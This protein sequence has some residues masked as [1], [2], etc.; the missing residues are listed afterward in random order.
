MIVPF[1][2]RNLWHAH[3]YMALTFR[4]EDCDITLDIDAQ[5]PE[6]SDAWCVQLARS[7]FDHGW[8]IPPPDAHGLLDTMTSWCP[9]C[10]LKR[11][12]TQVHYEA[13]AAPLI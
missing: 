9:Q 1:D 5:H 4:C 12:L 8:F 3:A 7:G 10:G 11:E 13:A 6:C 2:I